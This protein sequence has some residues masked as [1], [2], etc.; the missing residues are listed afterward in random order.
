MNVHIQTL[1][2]IHCE[3]STWSSISIIL[4]Q[5]EE[6]AH[7]GGWEVRQKRDQPQHVSAPN[8]APPS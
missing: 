6:K 4:H 1:T 5:A 2:H 8:P 3:Q 7:R